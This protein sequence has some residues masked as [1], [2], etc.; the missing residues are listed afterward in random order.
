MNPDTRSEIVTCVV[1][2]IGLKNGIKYAEIIAPD[3]RFPSTGKDRLYIDNSTL[4]L[5]P[6][7]AVTIE[8][9]RSL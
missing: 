3:C 9:R 1:E 6:G 8:I 4:D 2:S 7:E 5:Q